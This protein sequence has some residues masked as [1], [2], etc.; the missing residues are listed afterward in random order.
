MAL[1]NQ[2]GPLD[3]LP[4][5]R[6]RQR[7]QEKRRRAVGNPASF[8]SAIPAVEVMVSRGCRSLDCHPP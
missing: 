4:L 5:R 3:M 2:V 6:G 1:G 7:T 8:P